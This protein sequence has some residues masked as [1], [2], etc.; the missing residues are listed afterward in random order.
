MAKISFNLFRKPDAARVLLIALLALCGSVDLTRGLNIGG[1]TFL[2][3]ATLVGCGAAWA[4]WLMRP[5]LP[6]DLIKP[7]LPLIMFEL[8]ATGSMTW[9]SP[10]IRGLQLLAVG[11]SFLGLIL[12]T[13]R[14]TDRDPEFADA[15]HK[16]LLV[17]AGV[18]VLLYFHAI[19]TGGLAA[20]GLVNAR[21]FALYA[22]VAVAVAVARWQAGSKACLLWAGVIALA[23]FLSLSRTALVAILILIP[24]GVALRGDRKSLFLA[25][26][27]L[28]IGAAGFI[29]AVLTY[30][31]LYDRFFGYDVAMSVGGVGINA[32][33]RTKMWNTLLSTL[34]DD[35][36]FGKGIASSGN[37]IDEF[38]PDLGHPHNDFLRFY[39]DLGIVGLTL[40]LCFVGAFISKAMANLRRS[41]RY[42]TSDYPLHLAPL[43]ALAAVSGSMFT[44]NSV[45]YSFVMMPLAI[46]IGCS[47][48]AGRATSRMLAQPSDKDE[49]NWP[50]NSSQINF[51]QFIHTS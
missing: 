41:I 43:L 32:S 20:D 16:T 34:G 19:V 10:G 11:L 12:L 31:P 8:Y 9:Y 23:V 45:S 37:L 13:A 17:T 39:Y 4:I 49:E 6:N 5:F 24:L 51:P 26:A 18:S 27:I 14:E 3:A 30:Q 2:G 22:M 38:F 44:D 36:V 21:P 15:L 25:A 35:W 42:R 50:S 46:V 29:T 1:I 28:G 47:L 33:G 7:L 40:W 48:G